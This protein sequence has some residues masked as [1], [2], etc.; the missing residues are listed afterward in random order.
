[1][2]KKAGNNSIFL[3]RRD[4]RLDDNRG[5]LRCVQE[6]QKRDGKIMPLFIYNEEQIKP[7]NNP[8]FSD[9]AVQ[10][11]VES[12]HDLEE[13][14]KKHS[15]NISSSE[16]KLC[17]LKVKK[18]SDEAELFALLKKH[19]GIS[20]VYT[21]Q[22]LTPFARKRQTHLQNACRSLDVEFVPVEDYTLFKLDDKDTK[23]QEGTA[24]QVFSF[25]YA[26][27]KR[28]HAKI[29]PVEILHGNEKV[30]WMQKSDYD[31]LKGVLKTFWMNEDESGLFKENTKTREHFGKGGRKQALLKLLRL[32][33]DKWE[34]YD[35][36]RDDI[37]NADGTTRMSAYLKFGCLSIREFYFAVHQ[38]YGID[39]A[40]IR[41]MYFREF[42][43]LITWFYPHVL[44]GMTGKKN[45]EFIEKYQGISWS[46]NNNEGW[47]KWK[48]GTTGT[49]MVD[50]AMRQL[51]HTGFMHNRGRM[52][53]AQYLTKDLMMDWRWGEKYFASRLVDYDPAQNS[54]GWQ[55][56]ASVGS[57]AAPYFRIFNPYTQM[58]RFDKD[59][60][61]IK[62]W[63]PELKNV[64]PT[65]L[66]KWE[67]DSIRQKY[68]NNTTYPDPIV[69]NHSKAA[70]HA[71]KHFEAYA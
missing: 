23:T 41:E 12:L 26:K 30:S 34:E 32:K 24:Y 43:Y 21:N 49:P 51:N 69:K 31:K 19:A 35:T 5:L 36:T 10:F 59:A 47:E 40:L 53:V 15:K 48:E 71:K 65:D 63:V 29:P 39:H 14:L 64:A 58:D 17:K 4:F 62:R 6:T 7:D 20:H 60:A 22:D 25:L 46:T 9:T 37:S 38:S 70:E 66:I 50:A 67:K 33:D 27:R 56:S 16:T 68:R 8:Y 11:M 55:W 45:M 54:A 1:M 52:I 28:L 44:Q 42:Y 13:Q 3:F 57:D 61:Y 18:A 2:S